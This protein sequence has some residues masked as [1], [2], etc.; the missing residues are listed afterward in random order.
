MSLHATKTILYPFSPIVP[1]EIVIFYTI[2]KTMTLFDWRIGTIDWNS[3]GRIINKPGVSKGRNMPLG[4]KSLDQILHR[5][6]KFIFQKLALNR[7]FFVFGRL[8]FGF[9]GLQMQKGPNSDSAIWLFRLI[10]FR[11]FDTLCLLKNRPCFFGLIFCSVNC[12]TIFDWYDH[13]S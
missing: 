5:M 7:P 6:S 10:D 4:R 11:P 8:I 9:T 12:S 1:E 3:F 2:F 13:G